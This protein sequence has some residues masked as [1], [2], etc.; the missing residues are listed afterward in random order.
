MALPKFKRIESGVDV[1]PFLKEIEAMRRSVAYRQVPPVHR[2]AAHIGLRAPYKTRFTKNWY[3]GNVLRNKKREHYDLFP[4]TTKWLE[5]FAES[6]N[7]SLERVFIALLR[8]YGT[9]HRHFDGGFY[10]RVVDRYHLV[11]QSE[12]T[13]VDVGGTV[14]VF[15]QGEVWWFN[16]SH[17]HQFSHTSDKE[18]IHIIFDIKRR[19]IAHLMKNIVLRSLLIFRHRL[20]GA[21]QTGTFPKKR[22]HTYSLQNPTH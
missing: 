5:Q 17:F 6:H 12:G 18:R 20:R 9:I 21:D 22:R 10:F 7:A 1:Q 8:P 4:Y 13:H 11:L 19:S 14:Q 2:E 3:D 15:H 16:N